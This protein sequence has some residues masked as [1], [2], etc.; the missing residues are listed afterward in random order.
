[1]MARAAD[2]V[3]AINKEPGQ[4][5]VRFFAVTMPTVLC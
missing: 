3:S 1:M 4:V 5:S 2:L